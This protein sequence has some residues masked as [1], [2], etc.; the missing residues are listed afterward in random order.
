MTAANAGAVDRFVFRTRK[1]H[2]PD[3]LTAKRTQPPSSWCLFVKRT[4]Q[5]SENF[6]FFTCGRD[7]LLRGGD[8]ER[9]SR[10]TQTSEISEQF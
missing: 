7:G 2:L 4:Q 6:Y 9:P 8:N 5:P 10:G 1:A 3:K